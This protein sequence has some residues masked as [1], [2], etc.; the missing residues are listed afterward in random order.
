MTRQIALFCGVL[1]VSAARRRIRFW[2]RDLCRFDTLANQLEEV[3]QFQRGS[4]MLGVMEHARRFE[5][6][7]FLAWALGSTSTLVLGCSDDAGETLGGGGTGAGTAGSGAGSGG[8]AGSAAG[9]ATGG[10]G[11][12]SAGAAGTPATGGGGMSGGSSGSGGGG[13]AAPTPD[14]TTK[15]KVFISADHGHVLEVSM[16]DVMAGVAKAY[17]TKGKADH[18]HWVQL[19]PADFA[20]LQAGMSVHK[21]SCNDGHEHEFIVNC[22]GV[23]KPDTTSGVAGSCDTE[24]K[25]GDA[26]TNV[27]KELI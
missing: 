20:K 21:L 25:C 1:P 12:S 18:S 24:H 22:V 16:A 19:L 17:D 10:G 8:A 14:C 2:T 4:V 3:S 13:G 26:M 27:C 5:R 23:E 6:K 15:L 9:M 7:V 11:V